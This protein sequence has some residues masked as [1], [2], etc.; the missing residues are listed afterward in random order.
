MIYQMVIENIA[1]DDRYLP[2]SWNL[3][4]DDPT[5]AW[6]KALDIAKQEHVGVKRI[7]DDRGREVWD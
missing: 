6:E 2:P 7:L 5:E 1:D 3:E 4:A